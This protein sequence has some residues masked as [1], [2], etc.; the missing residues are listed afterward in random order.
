MIE[1]L[2]S[3]SKCE[4]TDAGSVRKVTEIRSGIVILYIVNH[5]FTM[6]SNF[7]RFYRESRIL[8]ILHRTG[9]DRYK[10]SRV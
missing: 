9:E 6:C 8:W 3:Y 4:I 5:Q 10:L 1:V 2:T 7:V